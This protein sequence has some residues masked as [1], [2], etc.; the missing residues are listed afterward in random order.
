MYRGIAFLVSLATGG[1]AA[2]KVYINLNGIVPKWLGTI[3]ISAGV[4]L[5]VTLALY[6][7]LLRHIAD[8]I[9]DQFS[10]LK[11]RVTSRKT[12]V[13]L[14]AIPR[15]S[16]SPRRPTTSSNK[17]L[18]SICGGPGGPICDRCHDKMSHK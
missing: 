14:D 2:W 13:D 10:T 9:E 4:L 6:L 15:T 17:A 11:V 16:M 5:V 7:P 1:L 12:G 18:C 3:G 8:M